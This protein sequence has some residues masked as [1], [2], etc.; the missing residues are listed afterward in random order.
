M[1]RSK[2]CLYSVICSLALGGLYPLAETLNREFP[3]EIGLSATTISNFTPFSR[4]TTLRKWFLPSKPL[5]KRD[6]SMATGGKVIEQMIAGKLGCH[7][8]Q[9]KDFQPKVGAGRIPARCRLPTGR[10]FASALSRLARARRSST[11]LSAVWPTGPT[12]PG[13]DTE[14]ARL[15]RFGIG[16]TP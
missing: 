4:A 8:T 7:E 12:R 14:L 2:I 5:G 10:R 15:R 13:V 11:A 16:T 6:C 1:G 3:E 9:P